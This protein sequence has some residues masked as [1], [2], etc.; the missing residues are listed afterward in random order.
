MGVGSGGEDSGFPRPSVSVVNRRF[1]EAAGSGR[2][3]IQECEGCGAVVFP[4]RV[5]CPG[6]FG[7]LEWVLAAGT[8]RVYSY[9]VV[10]RPNL[11]GVFGGRVPFVVVVVELD[12]GCRMV[13][14]LRNC[15]DEEV[16]IGMRVGVVFEEVA[17][18]FWLPQFEPI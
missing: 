6:C 5:A 2:L 12:E 17:S 14:N 10:H 9:G 8:G 4:P 11:P 3:V 7:E 15:P 18:G 13:T 1:W 16:E